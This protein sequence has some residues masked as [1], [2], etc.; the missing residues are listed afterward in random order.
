MGRWSTKWRA[1]EG[2]RSHFNKIT[3]EL[4]D[5]ER[6]AGD[7]ESFVSA[8]GECYLRYRNTLFGANRVDFA[9]QQRLVY[10]LLADEAV[11][12]SLVSSIHYVMVDEF[13]DTNHVQEEV[14]RL[15]ASGTGN[16][17]AI[18]D[19]DQS[20][21]RFRGATVR[22]LLE[23]PQRFP[24]AQ[25]IILGTNYRSHKT[26]VGAYDRWMA[27]ADWS[28]PNGPAFRFDKTIQPDPTTD[29]PDYPAVFSIRGRGERDEAARVADLVGFLKDAQ[30]IHP[31]LQ[32]AV[33]AQRPVHRWAGGPWYP[34][35]LPP[36]AYLVRERRGP[37]HDRG[38]R[39]GLRLPRRG[40]RRHAGAR[41]RQPRRLLRRVHR[42]VGEAMCTTSP[43][44]APPA[45]AYGGDRR[46]ARR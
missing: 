1:V 15:L 13:Q 11:R 31:S 9:H 27:S 3:E 36:G 41:A 12:E 16:L 37:A 35:L 33:R 42:R 6:L 19:E 39:S 14:V 4:I 18:G 46:L 5:P 38:V 24:E 30:V 25:R 26:I 17:A 7:S 21:Y 2:L 40:A 29:Y 34:D 23:F 28:N 20:L 43:Y 45:R 8:I 32:R 22:N 10:D 44:G